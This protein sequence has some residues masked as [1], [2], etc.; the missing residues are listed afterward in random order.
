MKSEDPKSNEIFADDGTIAKH[1]EDDKT[2]KIPKVF[3]LSK[4]SLQ[5]NVLFKIEIILFKFIKRKIIFNHLLV[6][7]Y[8]TIFNRSIFHSK[9]ID[10]F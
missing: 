8:Y 1:S 5:Y 9:L 6:H 10:A 4:F 7:C 2:I 3:F